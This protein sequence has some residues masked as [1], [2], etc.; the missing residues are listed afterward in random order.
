MSEETDEQDNIAPTTSNSDVKEEAEKGK[1]KGKAKAKDKTKE[2][3]R[4]EVISL[5]MFRKK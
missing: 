3:K 4:G 2:E 5:D 1:S